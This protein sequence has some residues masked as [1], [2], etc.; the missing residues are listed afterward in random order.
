MPNTLTC[1]GQKPLT[2]NHSDNDKDNDDY[3]NQT[4]NHLIPFSLRHRTQVI[5]CI[6]FTEIPTSL[7]ASE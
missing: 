5:A 2:S 6:W 4:G 1:V 7:A 3:D